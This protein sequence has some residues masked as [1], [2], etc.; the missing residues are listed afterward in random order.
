MEAR[1]VVIYDALGCGS[2]DHMCFIKASDI[3]VSM[4]HM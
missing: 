3:H 1:F 4:K 2:H